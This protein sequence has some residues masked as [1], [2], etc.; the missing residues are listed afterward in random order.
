MSEPQ[1]TETEAVNAYLDALVLAASEG[2]AQAVAALRALWRDAA[3]GAG[4][5]A[6][7]DA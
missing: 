2:D 6:E 7:G 3:R 4:E 1:T 5:F